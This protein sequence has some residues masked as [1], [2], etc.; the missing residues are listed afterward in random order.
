MC[1][2]SNIISKM[3]TFK[4]RTPVQS[5]EIES[6]E[7]K[8]SLKFNRDYKECLMQFGQ[9]S[10]YGHEFTGLTKTLRLNIVEVTKDER[11]K[12]NFIPKDLYVIEQT[13]IDDIVIWQNEQGEIFLS[14]S[15]IELHKVA[16]SLLKYIEPEMQVESRNKII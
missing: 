13:H 5:I 8:L 15:M 14:S 11:S 3:K 4:S 12:N 6:A 16:D 10:I 1:S 2:I 7:Q 9:F